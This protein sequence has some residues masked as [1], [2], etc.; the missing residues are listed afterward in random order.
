M[1]RIITQGIGL[2]PSAEL[3]EWRSMLALYGKKLRRSR[4]KIINGHVHYNGT[5]DNLTHYW[6]NGLHCA[7]VKSSLDGKRLQKDKCFEKR[8]KGVL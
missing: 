8:R 6:L 5:I 2:N 7:R 4:I 3:E 1:A